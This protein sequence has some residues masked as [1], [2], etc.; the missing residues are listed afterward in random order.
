ML[1]L[2]NGLFCMRQMTK[3]E[4]VGD[5]HQAVTCAAVRPS[6]LSCCGSIR[7]TPG[8]ELIIMIVRSSQVPADVATRTSHQRD[9][10][11]RGH[12]QNVLPPYSY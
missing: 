1:S 12:R 5:A 6:S 7:V 2:Q 10:G 8:P 11:P 9:C 3:A 4:R